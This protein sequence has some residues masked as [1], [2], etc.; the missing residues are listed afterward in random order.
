[1]DQCSSAAVC[2]TTIQKLIVDVGSSH[3]PHPYA[4][5]MNSLVI[6]R[7]ISLHRGGGYVALEN[8]CHLDMFNCH[9]AAVVLKGRKMYPGGRNTFHG[10][11]RKKPQ[12]A[13][14]SKAHSDAEI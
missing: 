8:K 3:V 9:V 5:R 13:S 6:N 10:M 7:D 1:M 4:A 2:T 12:P 11:R 14:V